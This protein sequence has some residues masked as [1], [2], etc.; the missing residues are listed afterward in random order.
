MTL[1]SLVHAMGLD[2]FFPM[3]IKTK[4]EQLNDEVKVLP[5][6]SETFLY[7]EQYHTTYFSNNMKCLFFAHTSQTSVL[8]VSN[9]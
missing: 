4:V 5:Y 8:V 9:T 3:Q 6:Y 1:S 2:T 7:K